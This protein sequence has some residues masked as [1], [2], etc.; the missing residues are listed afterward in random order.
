MIRY[1]Q[2]QS[3]TV[4]ILMDRSVWRLRHCYPGG[5]S[6][7]NEIPE[8]LESLECLVDELYSKW[9]VP[10]G[11]NPGEINLQ[12]GFQYVCEKLCIHM[13]RFTMEEFEDRRW[14]ELKAVACIYNFLNYHEQRQLPTSEGKEA[15]AKIKSW[16]DK[17]GQVAV[18]LEACTDFINKNAFLLHTATDRNAT[19]NQFLSGTDLE[20]GCFVSA[21]TI[22]P[23]LVKDNFQSV[24]LQLRNY[25]QMCGYRRAEDKYF[26]RVRTKG[27]M[28]PVMDT[29]AFSQKKTIV[30][31]VS[32]R[33]SHQ[34]YSLWER[35]TRP[36]NILKQLSDY[37]THRVIP[38]AP[39]LIE[40]HWLRSYGGDYLGRGAGVYCSHS[41]FFFTYNHREKWNDIAETV[42]EQRKSLGIM[43][44]CRAPQ[45][46]DVCII[47]LDMAFPYDTLNE[48]QSIFCDVSV[49]NL[50][51][52]EGFEWECNAEHKVVH[53]P[54][55]AAKLNNLDSFAEPPQDVIGQRWYHV[56]HLPDVSLTERLYRIELVDKDKEEFRKS[57]EETPEEPELDD[58]P[59]VH[60][61]SYTVVDD[62]I[63]IPQVEAGFQPREYVNV[64]GLAWKRSDHIPENF[65]DVTTS[66]PCD[67]LHEFTFC[68]NEFILFDRIPSLTLQ[69]NWMV[70]VVVENDTKMYVPLNKNG[71]SWGRTYNNRVDAIDVT[72]IFDDTFLDLLHKSMGTIVLDACPEM[73]LS[74]DC[75]VTVQN[76]GHTCCYIPWAKNLFDKKGTIFHSKAWFSFQPASGLEWKRVGSKLP[77]D[78]VLF[79]NDILAR[80]LETSTEF[81]QDVWD[82]FHVPHLSTDHHIKVG[83]SYFKPSRAKQVA[84]GLEWQIDGEP[85][86][87]GI[88]L[89]HT[90]LSK[91]L[92]H[93]TTFTM[94][95]WRQF[96]IKDLKANHY[97]KTENEVF[98]PTISDAQTR[99]FIRDLGR[100]W[101][102]CDTKEIDHIYNCQN[103]THHDLFYCYACK[104]R[105]L[106]RVGEKDAHQ[107]TLLF[108]GI[109]GCGKST[110]M[111]AQ[112]R[113]HP[114]HR[115]GVMSSNME[116]L[117]GMSQVIKEGEAEVIYCNECASEL[118]VKQEEWQISAS[119][120]E[121]SFARKN[122]K[123]WVGVCKAQ[124]FWV[125]NSRP[126]KFNDDQ[127]Q[128]TRRLM[129]AG[130]PNQVRPRDGSIQK[131]I[132]QKL[133]QLNR[134]EVVAYNQFLE[135]TGTIDPK[136][137]PQ[138][139]PPA[140]KD[141]HEKCVRSSDPVKDMIADGTFVKKDLGVLRMERFKE[142]F[143]EYRT[144]YDIKKPGRWT[145]KL[146]GRAFDDC[147]ARV[148]KKQEFLDPDNGHTYHNIEVISGLV[149][150]M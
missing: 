136:S 141:Y 87:D 58:P 130:M 61:S 142:L 139:L 114:S 129:G 70:H 84:S 131:V 62:E 97:V 106:F 22:N 37:L 10:H 20:K 38:E 43:I 34:N 23:S 16:M 107:F 138:K 46:R 133:G 49:G 79:H 50:A 60:P 119:G 128:A 65:C 42:N 116:P 66:L 1:E 30:E 48:I 59:P 11:T 101:M 53:L 118:N 35:A 112:Q 71:T 56:K 88:E 26:E 100:T 109:G 132:H 12:N 7:E 75:F 115:R 69:E 64:N 67:F 145:E 108:D 5:R 121:G 21:L 95:Q 96:G 77:Q 93:K 140:F 28:F 4:P 125:G 36:I 83:D 137:E 54:E 122:M 41:D 14:V 146:Y 9:I 3:G 63:Y 81:S 86:R 15:A 149:E 68:T 27:I 31:F 111:A 91:Q 55:F 73:T 19:T 147:S 120:E 6:N 39:N 17:T 24:F 113:F 76:E 104:G 57:L 92:E 94:M 102:D 32:E 135:I 143:Q 148:I 74:H 8:D 78:A 124:H 90:G 144:K 44:P 82:S 89:I 123:P 98:K 51:F 40:N 134:R 45:D 85:S 18:I 110:I 29:L 127:G 13:D 52:R 103:F 33:C 117:F 72:T 99:Y 150:V 2:G 25:L 80:K 126:T 105:L 47:H